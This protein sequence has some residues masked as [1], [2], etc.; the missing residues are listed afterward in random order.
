MKTLERTDRVVIP[1]ESVDLN[2]SRD[3]D[4]AEALLSFV[5]NMSRQGKT[6]TAQAVERMFTPQEAAQA[7]DVS[8]ATILRR[9]EDGTITASKRGTHW[10]ISESELARYQQTMLMET[11]A[12]MANDW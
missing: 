12:V 11:A 10:R 6:V 8:R 5:E 3:S 9:I 4:W 7:A 1:P 2:P